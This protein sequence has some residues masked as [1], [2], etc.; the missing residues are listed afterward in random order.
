MREG[1]LQRLWVAASRPQEFFAE[2]P[3]QPRLLR[4]VRPALVAVV[5]G[6][7]MFSWAI[8]R[9]TSSDSL[10]A[11]MLVVLPGAVLYA[12]T[13]WLLGGLALARTADL[14]ERGWEIAAWAWLP[15]GF[16]A[17][18]L[19]PVVAVFPV[20]SLV[21]GMLGLPI[22][23]LVVVHAGLCRFAPTKM[24]RALIIYGAV[25]LAIPL[26]VIVG[27]S[28][29]FLWVANVVTLLPPPARG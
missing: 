26:T 19:L 18:A 23:H 3:P 9:G 12:A 21:I 24:R 13:L 14:G 25:V 2:F 27:A 17:I 22:W 28:A 11:V 10:V 29:L 6:A 4:A 15:S 16:M 1:Y 8:A 20:T 5:L 7:V